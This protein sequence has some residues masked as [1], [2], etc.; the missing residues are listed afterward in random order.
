VPLVVTTLSTNAEA[1]SFSGEAEDDTITLRGYA[2]ET[3][4]LSSSVSASP[5]TTT[6]TNCVPIENGQ[7]RCYTTDLADPSGLI[8]ASSVTPGDAS[9][10][11]QALAAAA[12]TEFRRLPLASGGIA[13]Q[14]ARGWTLVNVDTIVRTD[15]TPQSFDLTLLGTPVEIVARPTSYSWLFGDG[16]PP[17]VTTDPGSSW[18]AHTLAHAYRA[19]GARQITL[20][21]A[22]TGSFRVAGSTT[23]TPIVGEAVTLETSPP[24][25]VREATNALV[26][27]S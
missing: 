17:L 27:T 16:S 25:D 3:P 2:I 18:P 11:V 14:P 6:V 22:W 4:R 1:A 15:P 26:A 9:P 12:A 8:L 24:F 19:A 7:L 5:A 23:W 21:T 20:T 13:R 10:G